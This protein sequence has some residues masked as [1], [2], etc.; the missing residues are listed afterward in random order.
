MVAGVRG[1][2]THLALLRV[3]GA[4]RPD[5]GSVIVPHPRMVVQTAP[6]MLPVNAPVVP[7]L[8]QPAPLRQ[9]PHPLRQQPHLAVVPP[10]QLR[11]LVS[12]TSKTDHINSSYYIYSSFYIL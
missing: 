8:V 3:V 7:I 12:I 10:V 9:Q 6:E 11:L 1:L 5:E 2:T 4:N